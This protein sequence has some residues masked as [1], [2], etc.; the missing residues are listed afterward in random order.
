MIRPTKRDQDYIQLLPKLSD[1]LEEISKVSEM[2]FEQRF[3]L[4]LEQLA[5]ES[6]VEETVEGDLELHGWLELAWADAPRMI[7][8]GCNDDHLPESLPR[9]VSCLN[10]Y[11][12]NWVC[13]RT[14]IVFK[15]CLFAS[16]V[17]RIQ[18]TKGA[19]RFYPWQIQS[20]RFPLRPSPLF[21]FV[22]RMIPKPCPIVPKSYSAKCLR[23]QEPGLGL[24][25][26]IGTGRK[27]T[28]SSNF[29]YRL[30][31]FFVLSLSFLSEEEVWHAGL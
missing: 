28:R 10:P 2:N 16:L 12:V 6:W 21:S 18:K 4:L 27:E 14:R 1:L 19:N 3:F 22:I 9:I 25:L 30:S 7:V 20:G 26:E 17:G 29:G 24:P 5:Q 31:F 15:G 23:R 13:G 11:G 8:L